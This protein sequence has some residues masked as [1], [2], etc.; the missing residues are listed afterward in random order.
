MS[1]GHMPK[2]SPPT[3]QRRQGESSMTQHQRLT[4]LRKI[5]TD[6]RA[7]LRIRVTACLL[8]LYAQPVSRIVRLTVDDIIRLSRI[9]R[10]RETVVTQRDQNRS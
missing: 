8:L 6:E 5:L 2:L 7:Q 10:V 1:N 9:L 3:I 4:L